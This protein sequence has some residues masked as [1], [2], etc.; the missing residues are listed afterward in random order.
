VLRG[1]AQVTLARGGSLAVTGSILRRDFQVL[2]GDE[3]VLSAVRR[4][5]SILSTFSEFSVQAS[6]RLTLAEVVAIVHIWRQLCKR[7]D[8]SVAATAATSTFVV[9]G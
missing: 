7:D 3:L 8:A 2:D 5:G 9:S 1:K 4:G 6:D